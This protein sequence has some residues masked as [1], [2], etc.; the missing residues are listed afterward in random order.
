MLHSE[1]LHEILWM[2]FTHTLSAG[3]VTLQAMSQVREN[4]TGMKLVTNG[5]CR[6]PSSLLRIYTC[7]AGSTH[8]PTTKHLSVF[9]L[10]DKTAIRGGAVNDLGFITVISRFTFKP[11]L[12]SLQLL[13]YSRCD[14][15]T[16][17]KFTI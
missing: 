16:G 4:M 9:H 8:S 14:L 17:Y 11:A 2:R 6:P 12:W 13:Y 10:L 15:P 5:L 1:W 7:N 3:R